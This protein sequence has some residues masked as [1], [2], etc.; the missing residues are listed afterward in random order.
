MHVSG[1]K[2]TVISDSLKTAAVIIYQIRSLW[3][4]NLLVLCESNQQM[5]AAVQNVN[6]L[7][8]RDRIGGG[9]GEEGGGQGS[10]AL[11]YGKEG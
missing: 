6:A 10:W 4:Y 1:L 2:W 3:D 8:E 5:W 7:L 11:K 9:E